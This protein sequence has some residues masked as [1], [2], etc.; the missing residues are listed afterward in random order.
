MSCK[1]LNSREADLQ[2]RVTAHA[3]HVDC[4]SSGIV[5]AAACGSSVNYLPRVHLSIASFW[6]WRQTNHRWVLCSTCTSARSRWQQWRHTCGRQAASPSS[7]SR[8]TCPPS[9]AWTLPPASSTASVC[10]HVLPSRS[11]E[12]GSSLV[13]EVSKLPALQCSDA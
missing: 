6:L 9:L 12:Y 11:S 1:Q 13:A 5:P 8:K 3:V 4:Q 7:A 10:S 2:R